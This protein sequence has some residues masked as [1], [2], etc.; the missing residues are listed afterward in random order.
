MSERYSRVFSLPENLYAQ[1]SP[2]I[3]GAGALL[4]DNQTGKVLVQ[5]KLKSL[6]QKPIKA[7]T[8]VIETFDT[9]EKPLGEEITHQYLDLEVTRD[10]EFGQKE[11][12]A[13]PDDVT[14]SFAVVVSQVVF[15]DNSTWEDKGGTWEP[16][17]PLVRLAKSLQDD[18][19][20]KQ[21]RLKYG[22][23]CNYTY[24]EVEDLWYC[25]CGEI[26]RKGEA[27][28]H[29]QKSSDPFAK[30]D[31][32][33]LAA[34]RDA[35]LVQEKKEA[36]ERAEQQRKEDAKRQAEA[37]RKAAKTKKATVLIVKLAAIAAVCVI[38]IL[39]IT[40]VIVPTVQYNGAVSHMEK[41]DYAEAIAVFE[42]L[43]GYKDSAE[44]IKKCELGM[45]DQRYDN[46]ILLMN[47]G[48][49]D[50][51][52]SA[53]QAL[54]GYRDSKEQ[55]KTCGLEKQY[56][57]ALDLMKNGEYQ[58]AIYE[59]G[60]TRG[61]KDSEEQMENCRNA[62]QELKYLKALDDMENGENQKAAAAFQALGKYKDSAELLVTTATKTAAEYAAEGDVDNAAIWYMTAGKTD[63]AYELKYEYILAHKNRTDTKTYDYLKELKGR[64]YRDTA[65]IYASLYKVSATLI[66][67]NSKTNTTTPLTTL[68]F[69]HT[70]GGNRMYMH[71]S[72]TGGPPAGAEIRIE[73]QSRWD[74]DKDYHSYPANRMTIMG[75][76]ETHTDRLVT[77]LGGAYYRIT[78]YNNET[79][80]QLA[81]ATFYL[82]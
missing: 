53:F 28:A 79:D 71:Y 16:L 82:D 51:A 73:K 40:K 56:H 2:V 74:T 31:M 36:A 26:N 6:S 63:K 18:E 44:Q 75:D 9:A 5:L 37:E 14:R 27:C 33:A 62:I 24:Q 13:L 66:L 35:R 60:Q 23:E 29:C 77:A 20:V 78:I 81:Q 39:L 11:P 30:A 46:A 68:K 47:E 59:F 43:D 38:G 4:K 65:S 15:Q 52:I 54:D 8:V 70:P 21:Y 58:A 7:A 72:I 50:E 19:L 10:G 17:P 42:A 69:N 3:I 1:G 55:I 49:Y 32:K 61:Y 41:G 22:S 76:G 67:N 12:I 80:E 25:P 45:L 57:T 64:G 34:E 48:K